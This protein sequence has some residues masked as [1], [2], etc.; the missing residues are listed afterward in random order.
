MTVPMTLCQRQMIAFY[1]LF[2]VSDV[3]RMQGKNSKDEQ[4]KLNLF[5][6]KTLKTAD[7]GKYCL[8]QNK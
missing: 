6:K 8:F 4:R 1:W 5:L 3:G 2:D 7:H